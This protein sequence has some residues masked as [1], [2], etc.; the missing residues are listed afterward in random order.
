MDSDSPKPTST[1]APGVDS[2][3]IEF[4]SRIDETAGRAV[5]RAGFLAAKVDFVTA[6]FFATDCA[7]FFD[8]LATFFEAVFFVDF[9]TAFVADFFADFF[10]DFGVDFLAAFLADFF[11]DFFADVAAFFAAFFAICLLPLRMCCG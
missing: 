10:T 1:L 7:D 5:G 2:P 8:V 4:D 9:F 3:S 6:F 11:A